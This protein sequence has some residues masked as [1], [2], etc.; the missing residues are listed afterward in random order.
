MDNYSSHSSSKLFFFLSTY[1]KFAWPYNL[2]WGL[3]LKQKIK[4]IVLQHFTSHHTNLWNDTYMQHD[5]K[6]RWKKEEEISS[7]VLLKFRC[8]IVCLLRLHFFFVISSSF[9]FAVIRTRVQGDICKIIIDSFLSQDAHIMYCNS[10]DYSY[11]Y[12]YIFA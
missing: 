11:Y 5:I 9:F 1:E 10:I 6:T 8:S 3:N 2:W 4:S 12:L 7:R